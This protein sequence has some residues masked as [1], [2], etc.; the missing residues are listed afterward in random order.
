[1][2]GKTTHHK[3][4]RVVAVDVLLEVLRKGQSLSR[5][6]PIGQSKV[7]ERDRALLQELTFGVLRWH[8]RLS[9]IADS[10]MDKPLKSRDDDIRLLILLG[11]YQLEWTSIAPH[12]V[13]QETVAV[14]DKRRKGWARGLVNAVL[15]RYQREGGEPLESVWQDGWQAQYSLPD[16]L[17]S[18]FKADW[19]APAWQDIAVAANQRPPMTLRVNQARISR[20]DYLRQ[21]HEHGLAASA[22]SDVPSAIVLD[23]PAPVS[24]LPG[25]AEGLCSVQDAGAQLAAFLLDPQPGDRILD[26]CAAPGGKTCHLLERAGD[27]NVLAL[28]NDDTRCQRIHENLNRIGL[29]AEVVCADA[30]ATE[31]WWDGQA[32]DR[33][34]LD[35]P[36]SALGVIRRHP[37]IRHLRKPADL[38]ALAA[39]QMQI[40]Q[41]VW[42]TLKPGGRLLYAT[43]S[44]ARQENSAQVG[45]FLESQ[46]D[47]RR[48]NID[49]DWGQADGAGRQILPG[50]GGMDGFFYALLEKAS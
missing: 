38:P 29:H 16:W 19:P 21:L 3:A 20:E 44:V 26:A 49:A 28:D 47:A 31:R 17:L 10:L 37:D 2:S 23:S 9:T 14:A 15:R 40:L 33:I 11:L 30:A 50:Q 5:A 12:A 18:Q 7:A 25:F 6:L 35:V 45:A 36:C 32:F 46:G 34:L 1:M 27:A 24:S 48:I 13:L 39:L 22:H 4:V 8:E 41:A 43:C 42:P